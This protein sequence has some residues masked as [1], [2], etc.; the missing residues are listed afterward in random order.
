MTEFIMKTTE[1]PEHRVFMRTPNQ[2]LGIGGDIG[3]VFV[4]PHWAT[5]SGVARLGDDDVQILR[6]MSHD[7]GDDRISF[8]VQLIVGPA[9]RD[10]FQCAP[11]IAPRDYFN[12]NADE[13]DY[14][15][16]RI[17]WCLWE[18]VQVG[19]DKRIRLKFNMSQLGEITFFVGIT[20]QIIATGFI[21]G[22]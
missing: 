22:N 21:V 6:D 18:K 19:N 17:S 7:A 11:I 13:D 20:Y 10:V 4:G 12:L 15:G 3:Q 1:G 2:E 9:W 8:D 16:F 14:Q 5:C